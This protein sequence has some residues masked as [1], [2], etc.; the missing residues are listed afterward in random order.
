MKYKI[1]EELKEE[2]HEPTIELWFEDEGDGEVSVMG[3]DEEGKVKEIIFFTKDGK[4]ARIPSA[5]LYGMETD[6]ST[7]DPGKIKEIDFLKV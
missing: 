1:K 3:R 7:D 4:F 5:N 2:K 6:E